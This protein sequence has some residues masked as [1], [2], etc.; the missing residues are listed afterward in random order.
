MKR[1]LCKEMRFIICTLLFV[2]GGTVNSSGAELETLAETGGPMS[3]LYPIG[4]LL[5]ILL[6]GLLLI[7]FIR[8][9][10]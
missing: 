3:Y 4:I 5:F 2:L 6:L 1:G 10:K 8:N 7:D 9:K